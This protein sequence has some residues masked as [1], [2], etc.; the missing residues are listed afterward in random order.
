MA[1]ELAAQKI[2]EISA[3]IASSIVSKRC[4]LP[5]GSCSIAGRIS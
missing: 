3:T 1:N 4:M 5:S 2:G